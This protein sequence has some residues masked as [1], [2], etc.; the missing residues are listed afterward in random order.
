MSTLPEGWSKVAL[1]D[2]M[3]NTS[4][5]FDF[6][7]KDHVV[8]VN[9]GDVLEGNFLHANYISAEGLPGQA[10]KAIEKGDI[11]YSEI[12]P[13]NKRYALVDFQPKDYVVSTKFMVLKRNDNV[14]LNFLY[15]LLTSHNMLRV[16]N[17]NAEARSGTFP[18]ITFDSISDIEIGLPPLDEQ[19]S[20]ANIL[21][22]FDDKIELL[23]E[24]NKTLETLAQTLFKEWFVKFNFPGA[25]GEM[26]DSELGE[27]PKGW[28]AGVLG[29][30][31]EI[32][33]GQSPKGDTY[34]E[35]SDGMVFYQGRAEFQERFPKRRLYTTDP[36]RIAKKF[37]VLMSVRA[38]VGDINV[39]SEECC[40]GRGLSAIYSNHKSYALYKM[41]FLKTRLDTFESEGTV[42]G[43]INKTS[44]GNLEVV[45]PIKEIIENYEFLADSFDK[46]IFNNTMQIQI[47]EKT[48]D[49]L[50][51]KLMSGNIRIN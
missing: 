23:R 9:T 22:S 17:A 24:Q 28:R 34:N 18:Q 40:I 4:R 3:Q 39:A 10:K 36:K 42:F 43:S 29:E 27:I 31:F 49:T 41:K 51:P 5:R 1:G 25:T 19:K 33:M 48:R 50:L 37:N 15:L 20:I 12:R 35:V 16:F 26:I 14:D 30:E 45:I 32:T 2:V 44:L 8:F 38:P 7:D 13:K 6:S 11:L 21:S 47:L 46:K